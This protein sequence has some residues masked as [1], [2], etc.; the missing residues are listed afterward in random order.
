MMDV[1]DL[2]CLVSAKSLLDAGEDPN[3]IYECGRAPLHRAIQLRDPFMTH[4]LLSHGADPRL[5]VQLRYPLWENTTPLHMAVHMHDDDIV[6]QLIAFG[7]NVH[8]V[9]SYDEMALH[10]AVYGRNIDMARILLRAGA[11][12]AQPLGTVLRDSLYLAIEDGNL[13]MVDL[14]FEEGSAFSSPYEEG[15]QPSALGELQRFITAGQPDVYEAMKAKVDWIETVRLKAI[16]SDFQYFHASLVVGKVPPLAQ[17]LPLLQDGAEGMFKEWAMISR[18]YY[19]MFYHGESQD[20]RMTDA[21][22]PIS[23]KLAEYLLFPSVSR[24][25]LRA[26]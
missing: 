22:G 23:E 20:R 14:L 26:F 17:L 8:E 6:Q 13:E 2:K 1:V 19:A 5:R 3:V 9:N 16:H 12:S 11:D 21:S 10:L 25:F 24:A 18:S 15:G 4:L 7:A